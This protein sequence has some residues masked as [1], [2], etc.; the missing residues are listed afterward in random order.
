MQQQQQ[1]QM[2]NCAK[3]PSQ[4]IFTWCMH[5][6]LTAGEICFNYNVYCV[7]SVSLYC[8][9]QVTIEHTWSIMSMIIKKNEGFDTSD[10]PAKQSSPSYNCLARLYL[11]GKLKAGF[12]TTQF[13]VPQVIN[14]PVFIQINVPVQPAHSS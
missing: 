9:R 2:N 3:L 1:Q 4:N 8:F 14:N 11:K 6:L 5:F 12:E 7:E 10:I 13:F